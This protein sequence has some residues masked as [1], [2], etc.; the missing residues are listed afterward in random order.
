MSVSFLCLCLSLCVNSVCN[1]HVMYHPDDSPLKEELVT[2]GLLVDR[3]QL[4][5]HMEIAWAGESCL[6]PRSCPSGTW[7][8]L[9]PGASHLCLAGAVLKAILALG[10]S[11]GLSKPPGALTVWPFFLSTPTFVPCCHRRC[12]L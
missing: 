5:A 10:I 11:V 8:Y 9:L 2:W 6:S 4:S 3:R 7:P 1:G 12:S